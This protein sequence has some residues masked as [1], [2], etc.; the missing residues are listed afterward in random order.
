MYNNPDETWLTVSN[1]LEEINQLC[2]PTKICS[3]YSKPFWNKHFTN[4]SNSLRQLRKQFKRTSTP[5]KLAAL[6]DAREKLEKEFETAASN[7]TKKKLQYFNNAHHGNEFWKKFR[8]V[9]SKEKDTSIAHLKCKKRSLLQSHKKID[10]LEYTYFKG[11]HLN[12]KDFDQYFEQMTNQQFEVMHQLVQKQGRDNVWYNED[13]QMHEL[14][15][16]ITKLHNTA[17]SFDENNFHSKMIV[18]S[19][20][21]VCTCLVNLFNSCLKNSL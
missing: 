18:Q 4:L 11:K 12:E 14:D 2:T 5:G 10:V 1:L 3:V 9:C 7:W 6:N 15:N 13:V 8:K 16:I 20:P 19:G 21:K 17:C